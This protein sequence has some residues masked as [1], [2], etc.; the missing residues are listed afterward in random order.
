MKLS[1]TTLTILKNYAEINSN[2]IINPGN[3][4]KTIHT[5]PTIYATAQ[6]EEVFDKVFG[7]YDLKEFL[8]T[9]AM[10]KNP[11][12]T[13]NENCVDIIDLDDP[14]I[15]TKYWSADTKILTPLPTLKAFPD[16]IATFTISNLSFKRIQKATA[17]L[18]CPDV[19]LK[20]EKGGAVQAIVCDLGTNTKNK[21]SFTVKLS[22]SYEGESFDVH[23]KQEKLMIIDGDY[24]CSVIA[25][26]LIKLN[27]TEK[28]IE[29]VVT[30]DV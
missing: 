15:R 16:P 29:Y 27:H 3:V 30:L 14:N 1:N 24:H 17:T 10:F 21:N 5:P 28:N 13:F 6:I 22:D 18:K 8:A 12:L 9:L 23:L 20:G 19:V 4:L 7:I 26:K 11:D 2:L 25:G